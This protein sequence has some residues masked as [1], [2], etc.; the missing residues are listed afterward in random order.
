MVA[1]SGLSTFS[2][3][4]RFSLRSS[5]IRIFGFSSV[6]GV[7]RTACCG[8]VPQ[9]SVLVPQGSPRDRFRSSMAMRSRSTMWSTAVAAS[10][11]RGMRDASAVSGILHDGKPAALLDGF[12]PLGAV[13]IGAGQHDADQRVAEGVRRAFEQ[14]IDRRPGI[15]DLVIDGQAEAAI[16]LDQQMIA[17]RRQI[18]RAR[19][20]GLLVFRFLDLDRAETVQVLGQKAVRLRARDAARWRWASGKRRRQAPE[21]SFSAHACR[22]PKRPGPP[23]QTCATTPTS[24]RFSACLPTARTAVLRSKSLRFPSCPDTGTHHGAGCR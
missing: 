17:R 7:D 4:S 10:A 23:P 5:T 16:R 24:C 1:R 18:S 3:A 2:V 12:E 22:Q 19:T 15:I 21:G 6:S 13:G 9:P 14:Q 8:N 20:E 11:A